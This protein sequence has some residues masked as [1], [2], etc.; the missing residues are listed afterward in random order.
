MDLKSCSGGRWWL[1]L[2][3]LVLTGSPSHALTITEI[4]YHPPDAGP[5]LQFVEIFNDA[6]T[7]VD[8]SNWFFSKGIQ[9][10]FPDGTFLEGRS[11]LVVCGDEAAV[12]TRY[13][14]SN[15]LGN[16]AGN[17]ENHG[18]TIEISDNN[19][20]KQVTVSYKDRGKWPAIPGG[21]GHSL[22]LRSPFLDPD[23]ASSWASS[24]DMGGTPGA[25]NITAVET[26]IEEAAILPP[27][28]FWKYKKGTA[29]FSSPISAW[30]AVSYD[31]TGWFSG[32]SGI[33]YGETYLTTL[34]PDMQG[35]YGSV[36]FRKTFTLSAAQI[37][38]MESV[39]LG[40]QYDDGFVAHL[41][42]AEV[43]R[44]PGWG[45]PGENVPFDAF[46]PLHEGDVE[47]IFPLS[48][49]SLVAGTNVLAVQ[50]HNA[51]LAGSSDFV[52]IPRLF[53]RRTINP[54]KAV[55]F[56]EILSRTAGE[57]WVELYNFGEDPI[58][59]SGYFLSDS[60]AQLGKHALPPGTSIDSHEF[61]VLTE[62]ASGL[63]LAGPEVK[64][65]LTSPDLSQVL[66]AHVFENPAEPDRT[67]YSDAR[68]PDGGEWVYS[69]TPTRGAANQHPVETDVVIGEIM[70]HPLETRMTTGGPV[71]SRPGE[72]IEIHNIGGRTIP[73]AGF[74][75]T[76]GIDYAF[77]DDAVLGPG[78]YLVVAQDPAWLM[79][80]YGIEDVVGPFTGDLKDSG[81][82]IRLEDPVGNT[83][84]EVK[85]ADGG[86]WPEMADGGG[87]S[88]ELIDP[89]QDNSVG[90]AWAASD[91]SGKGAWTQLSY[92]TSHPDQSGW[93]SMILFTPLETETFLL[94]D[95]ELLNGSTNYI[96][97]GGFEAGTDPWLMQGCLTHSGLETGDSHSGGACLRVVADSAGDLRTN[98]LVVGTSPGMV[99]G[100]YTVRFWVRWISGGNAVLVH[101]FDHA[102]AKALWF[103]VPADLGTPGRE[104]GATARLRAETGS[105][106]LGPVISGVGQTPVRPSQSQT[107]TVSVSASDADGVGSVQLFYRLNQRG[108]DVFN[109]IPMTGEG[110]VYTATVPGF[111][112][113]TKVLFYIEAADSAG[114]V[115]RYPLDAPQHTLLYMV[116]RALPMSLPLYRLSMDEDSRIYLE[117]RQLHS[118]DLVFGSLVFDDSEIFYN[119]GCHYHGSPWNRPGWPRMFKL[120]FP[121][122]RPF[123]GVKKMN[124]SR[125]GSAANEAMAYQTILRSGRVDSPSPASD[126][127]FIRW[128]V[129]GSDM[130]NMSQVEPVDSN[131][132]SR[133]YGPG[134]LLYRA[135][136]KITFRLVVNDP[137]PD[138]SQWVITS[139]A[140]LYYRSA[141]KESYRYNFD[142]H[143]R[144]LEDDFGPLL[145]WLKVMDEG[146][147]PSLATFDSQVKTMLD[148]EQFLRLE[149]IRAMN[150]DWD[151]VGVGNGQNVYYHYVPSEGRFK[152]VPWDMDHTF[153]NSNATTLI[154]Q[155][156]PDPGVR[157]L[158]TR[159]DLRRMYLQSFQDTLQRTWGK[160]FDDGQTY[161]SKF[162]D[163]LAAKGIGNTAGIK[164][165]I[166]AR[167]PII[168]GSLGSAVT[169]RISAVNNKVFTGADVAVN[170]LTTPIQGS[171]PYSI[172]AILMNGDLLGPP[173]LVWTAQ[174]GW[175][176]T[177]NISPGTTKRF[178][179]MSFDR[180]GN[181]VG[182]AA[183]NIISTYQWNA[184]TIQTLAPGVGSP[185]GGTLVSITGADFHTGAK[186]SFGA[187]DSGSV[188]VISDGRIDAVT[189]AGLGPVD[190]KVV[191]IDGKSVVKIRGFYFGTAF[192]RGDADSDGSVTINDPMTV[193]NFLFLSGDLSCLKAGD[194][195]DDGGVD[196]GD[197]I[198]LL[199]FL[200]TGGSPI[201][202]PYPDAGADP[203]SDGLGCA[204]AS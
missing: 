142:L 73:L 189:P 155:A 87:S 162:L 7:V 98:R 90:S 62:A 1:A 194:A 91:E 187:A 188:Q 30:R 107:V 14:I 156:S 123:H 201:P 186:V 63:T 125:Y 130:G 43:A 32:Q 58:D 104:N 119:V 96:P 74:A 111:V 198:R 110:K 191:N 138:P 24:R 193:L 179:F 192:L 181:L 37:A 129:N 22:C 60:A 94:D 89:R 82:T 178:E 65:F 168:N 46:A 17:L 75:F 83:V 121:A 180:D 93:D 200:F 164:N 100:P 105:V 67:G 161:L 103:P 137:I 172:T 147:T 40:L 184:P 81:E 108:D 88:L 195:N 69:S 148:V 61:L 185:A 20:T 45:N 28:V 122:D 52:F 23:D 3:P 92:A 128:E 127:R 133:R 139:W 48:K 54:G 120:F 131:Y 117:N 79:S 41:N 106:N 78:G 49:S 16:F 34:L 158:I 153:A 59:L 64:L 177:V 36:A 8:L 157:R 102:M 163:P 140:G 145:S 173:D 146:Q 47:E 84:D 27:N 135:N 167:T 203:T 53:Y 166:A 114:A 175:R 57:R 55:V 124:I 116:D 50:V 174:T 97:N 10:L 68:F 29:E 112:Q 152:H 143:S 150:D 85:Y 11:Y 6:G 134:G 118:D 5:N 199:V 44:T 154:S 15:T 21:T 160:T 77:A 33:G 132:A 204:E 115:R 26:G 39:F 126:Y 169:F 70:Y 25:A 109:P 13:A 183:V 71:E 202:E 86:D 99:T 196:V 66:D 2:V 42:G 56:N 151:T 136:G 197:A 31:E 19:G 4:M 144:E 12:Q 165:F 101:S 76:K 72:Y 141:D 113:G 176:V 170:T 171:A 80:T 95:V 38:R 182:S 9:F 190:V 51:N 149:A 18:E 159:P 35:A